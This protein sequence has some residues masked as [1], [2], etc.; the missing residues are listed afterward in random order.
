MGRKDSIFT[1]LCKQTE[2]FI[3]GEQSPKLDST[4]ISEEIEIARYNVSRDLNRLAEEGKVLK[5]S[6]RPV[7]FLAKEIIEQHIGN[8]LKSDTE[9]TLD[10]LRKLLEEDSKDSLN[11]FPFTELIGYDGSLENAVRQAKAALLY[12]PF[13]LHSLLTGPSGSGKT[14][15]ARFMYQYAKHAGKL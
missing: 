12:P 10:D 9:W 15:F 4:S 2:D 7:C 1:F 8:G 6:G 5:L 13:G 14:T 11:D 3:S